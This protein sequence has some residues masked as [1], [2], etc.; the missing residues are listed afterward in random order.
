MA[1]HYKFKSESSKDFS[2]VLF[3]GGFI[4][5]GEFKKAIVTQK[6]LGKLTDIDLEVTNAQTGESMCVWC[7]WDVCEMVCDG[8][9]GCDV[10]VRVCERMWCGE[11]MRENV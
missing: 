3:E 5:A 4:S 8:C 2:T 1:V 6:K 7:V 11:E 9:D 10:R